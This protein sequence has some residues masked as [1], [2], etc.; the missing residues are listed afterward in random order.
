MITASF[1]SISFNKGCLWKQELE[2]SKIKLRNE[3]LKLCVGGTGPLSTK[4]SQATDGKALK[5]RK[6]VHIGPLG[7]SGY[8]GAEIV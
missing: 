6:E 2:I 5:R 8:T 1:N 3:K 4:C 7:V